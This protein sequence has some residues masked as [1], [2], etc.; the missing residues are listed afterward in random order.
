M[1]NE[2][3]NKQTGCGRD[4]LTY[5]CY[6]S[7]KNAGKFRLA[8]SGQEFSV[9]VDGKISFEDDREPPPNKVSYSGDDFT[10]RELK[11]ALRTGKRVREARLRV[12]KGENTWTFTLRADRFEVSGLKLDM[13]GTDD[14]EERFFGRMLS[15]EGLNTLLD[16]LFEDFIARAC[17]KSWQTQGYMEFQSWL[18]GK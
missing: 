15:L 5:I 14:L 3:Q 8:E 10:D 11:Q 9:W 12:E 13:P 7:D 17:G 6:K 18:R 4:F 2:E 16:G 1:N